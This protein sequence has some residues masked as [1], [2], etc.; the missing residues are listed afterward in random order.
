MRTLAGQPNAAVKISGLGMTDHDWTVASLRP[1]V[2]ETIDA[3]GP[4]RSMF[5]S[6]FPVDRLYSSFVA[7]YEAFDTIT[8]G[9]SATDRRALFAETARRVYRLDPGPARS[10]GT[11][12]A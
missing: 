10:T 3:F 5:A 7:L 2:L 8:A 12:P 11:D 6:N 1:I 4:D 9:F